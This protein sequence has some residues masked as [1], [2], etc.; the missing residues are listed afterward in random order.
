MSQSTSFGP[1]EIAFIS[2][3]EDDYL[4]ER[5]F[6]MKYTNKNVFVCIFIYKTSF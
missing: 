1:F 4:I 3:K 6:E 5:V 2:Q